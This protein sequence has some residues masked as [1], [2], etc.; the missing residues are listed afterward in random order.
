[1]QVEVT[2][3]VG[4]VEANG[5]SAAGTGVTW[6][7]ISLEGGRG[8]PVVDGLLLSLLDEP[9]VKEFEEVKV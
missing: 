8:A 6:L 9:L 5:T 3:V 1:M 4:A 2:E 7:L